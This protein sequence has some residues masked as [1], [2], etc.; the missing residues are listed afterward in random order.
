MDILVI[1]RIFAGHNADV[2]ALLAEQRRLAF[3]GRRV[4]T[5]LHYAIMLK[6]TELADILIRDGINVHVRDAVWRSLLEYA[7]YCRETSILHL[8]LLQMQGAEDR[9]KAMLTA[10]Q[11]DNAHAIHKLL[12]FNTTLL[13]D[14]SH[15]VC[16]CSHTENLLLELGLVFF[17]F[18][19][20]EN[21]ARA[22]Q[23]EVFT[24]DELQ[25]V[26]LGHLRRRW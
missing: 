11:L 16:A 12:T 22:A 26:I 7:V 3:L 25:N 2:Q 13:S 6:K 20:A 15:H 24:R 21:D 18:R 14:L 5:P 19:K 4:M 9:C 10:V 17:Y 23:N 8:L 1:G